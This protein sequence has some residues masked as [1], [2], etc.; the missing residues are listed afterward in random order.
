[1]FAQVTTFTMLHSWLSIHHCPH[2]F[3]IYVVSKGDDIIGLV[4]RKMYTSEQCQFEMCSH[5]PLY[6]CITYTL[7]CLLYIP[8]FFEEFTSTLLCIIQATFYCSFRAA[9]SHMWHCSPR[10]L[11]TSEQTLSI[12]F[13]GMPLTACESKA[14]AKKTNQQNVM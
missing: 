12:H 2:T 7:S 3:K 9:S 5:H 10:S 11:Q 1:M 4:W 8:N 14:S 6:Y 13:Y